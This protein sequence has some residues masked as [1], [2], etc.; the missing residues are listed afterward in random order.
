MIGEA[1]L[2]KLC[3]S[4]RVEDAIFLDFCIV[5]SFQKHEISLAIAG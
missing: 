5:P 2:L 1:F 4:D 3:L